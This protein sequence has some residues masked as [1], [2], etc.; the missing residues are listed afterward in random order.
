M[1]PVAISD[2]VHLTG[3]PPMEREMV[4]FRA[5][6]VDEHVLVKLERH[7]WRSTLEDIEA[8]R[9]AE[10]NAVCAICLDDMNN[11]ECVTLPCGH[12]LHIVCAQ[13][14]EKHELMDKGG[15]LVC[16]LSVSCYM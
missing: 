8:T 11:S 6:F 4:D 9:G 2:F 10:V 14:S 16:R 1:R 3:T 13:M 7:M 15:Y 5:N 12:C